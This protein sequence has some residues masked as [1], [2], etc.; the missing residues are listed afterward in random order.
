MAKKRPYNKVEP[1][2]SIRDMM[3][4]AVAAMDGKPLFK[5]KKNGGVVEVSAKEFYGQTVDL[6]NALA[7]RGFVKDCHIACVGA[8]SYNWLVVYLSAL[9]G[10]NGAARSHHTRP[11]LPLRA[12]RGDEKGGSAGRR[13]GGLCAC[14]RPEKDI[15]HP[16]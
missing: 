9:C 2:D 12:S 15:S 6:G 16:L 10:Q 8:N 1:I 3:Q 7:S 5:Y 4:K 13:H 11:R 14:A